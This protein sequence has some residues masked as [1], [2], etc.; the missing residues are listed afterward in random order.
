VDDGTI[1]WHNGY[2]ILIV[3]IIFFGPAGVGKSV[4]GQLL[5]ARHGWRWLSA[6][7]VLRDIK[8]PSITD[9]MHRGVLLGDDVMH[10][11]MSEA[12]HRAHGIDHLILDGFP[13]EISQAHWLVDTQAEHGRA[14]EVAIVLEASHDE[15]MK[16]LIARGRADDTPEAIK[17]RHAVYDEQTTPI[18]DY[19]AQAGIPI[20]RIDG[21]GSVDKVHGRI[22][23]ALSRRG[24]A[25]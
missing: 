18:L 16:R 8:D 12:I 6:G 4:Q 19:L 2:G 13:R 10:K 20:E 15:L 3:M 5:A 1:Q 9:A 22:E 25:A 21:N 17:Q 7:Q 23:A 11:A 14:V 24:I